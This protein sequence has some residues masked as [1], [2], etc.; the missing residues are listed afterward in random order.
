MKKIILVLTF[1]GSF[2]N[3]V[4]A[5]LGIAKGDAFEI[6]NIGGSTVSNNMMRKIWLYRNQA[7]NDWLT[8]SLH[9]GIA[10]DV[11]FLQPQ[12]NTRTWWERNPVTGEQM[13]GDMGQTFMMLSGGNLGLGTLTPT[14]KLEVQTTGNGWPLSLRTNAFNPGDINGLKFYSG[15]IGDDK[16]A[17]IASVAEDLHSNRTGLAIYSG[18]TERVRISGDGNVG[19][20]TIAP[21]AML[22]VL[23]TA[24]FGGHNANLDVS[25]NPAAYQNLA[26]TGKMLIGWNRR[27]GAGETDFI[28]NEGAGSEGGFAFYSY[29]NAS[30]E[31]Q[32][33]RVL[34]NGDVGI[35][36]STPTE[37][38]TV[39]GKI[40]ANEIRVDG[41]GQPDYVFEE[42]YKI[43][44][45]R[46]TEQYIK[47]NKHLPEIPSAADAAK[48]GIALGE[49][50]KLLLKKIEEL[51]LH[52]IEK[53]KVLSDVQERLLIL[54]KNKK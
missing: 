22:E 50:N 51:T 35:G 46:E 27:A 19:I 10:V 8:A 52:L 2:F 1:L 29:N 26:G 45:L 39:N 20:G 49:M 21:S 33:L 9:D 28:A 23:G 40:K 5:Q 53:D 4:K 48:N 12:V 43:S 44:S 54:E 30:Q 38:L 31:Q 32:L 14:S 17:G 11:S 36:T 25:G 15:Y 37:R 6:S 3:N 13:W 47:F 41:N 7:G 42:G 16:W 24:K 34:G 18:M